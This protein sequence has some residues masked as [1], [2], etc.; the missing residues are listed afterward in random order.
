MQR[1]V[2]ILCI[3]S[4]L[5][6]PVLA[7]DN[8]SD[9]PDIIGKTVPQAEALLNRS[10]YQ[11]D[12]VIL[13][14]NTG[15]GDLNTV[16]GFEIMDDGTVQVT[17]LREYNVRLIWDNADA[18]TNVTYL[19]NVD[20][21]DLFTLV[22]LSGDNLYLPNLQIADFDSSAWEASLM[23]DQCAQIWT[24][25]EDAPFQREECTSI[26]GG[27]VTGITQSSAQFWRNGEDFEVYQNG[28]Y[29]ATC[30]IAAGNCELWLSPDDIAEDLTGY[31]YLIYDDD[32][33]LI[34]NNSETQ[35]MD[36]S[37]LNFNNDLA[38]SD[39]RNWDWMNHDGFERLAP[40]QC[41]RYTTDPEND[42]QEDCI[43]LAYQITPSTEI[44]WTEAFTLND[45]LNGN[46]TIECPASSGERTLCIAGR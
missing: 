31:V 32:E 18:F 22:N 27:N 37:R 20:D 11:L 43:E 15:D 25:T 9:F 26:R 38:L 5:L 6:L 8:E 21:D 7:Q 30:Q 16:S 40:G 14:T 41:L 1:Q 34:Y 33:L 17:V 28:I 12:P 29:R 45:S 23:P 2:L 35:W 46:A 39:V 10:L 24:F 19:G 42:K 44:F 3:L 4:L 13:S 36:V